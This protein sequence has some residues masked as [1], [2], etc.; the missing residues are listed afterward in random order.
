MAATAPSLLIHFLINQ[1]LQNPSPCPDFHPYLAVAEP[2]SETSHLH[3]LLGA[4]SFPATSLLF[5]FH[6]EN[7]I[8]F[9]FSLTWPVKHPFS[10]RAPPERILR[11][12]MN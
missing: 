2:P 9:T 10:L 5:Q 1:Q 8:F 6:P 4:M 3:G 7:Y 11:L 12:L